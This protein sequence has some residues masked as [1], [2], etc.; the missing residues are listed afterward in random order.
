MHGIIAINTLLELSL[1]M[2]QWPCVYLLTWN[3]NYVWSTNNLERRI[4]EHTKGE[5]STKRIWNR[6]LIWYIPCDSLVIARRI[7]RTIKQLW[8]YHTNMLKFWMIS[9]EQVG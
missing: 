5:Y 8:H 2:Y 6:E 1:N 4:S 3:L 7:E 9:V